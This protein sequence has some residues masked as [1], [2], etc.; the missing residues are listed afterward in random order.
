MLKERIREF[1]MNRRSE[2]ARKTSD[3]QARNVVNY[4]QVN[5]IGILFHLTEDVEPEP[6]G[7]FIKK[8]EQD[9][10]KVKSLTFLENTHSHPYRFYIDFFRKDDIKWNG[11]LEEI[12]KI[13]QFLD[14]QFDYLFCIESEPQ[15]VFN[16]L[17]QKSKANCRIGLFDEKR[18]NLFE[19]MVDNPDWKDLPHTLEQMLNYLKIL[20]NDAVEE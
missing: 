10:K 17:L 20:K 4:S 3:T 9:H 15:P 16:V 19:I 14:T 2:E 7:Q 18:T 13:R 8:L 11:N 6:L 5:Q 1:L 12:P